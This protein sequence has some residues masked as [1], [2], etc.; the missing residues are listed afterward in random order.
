[1]SSLLRTVRSSTRIA[2]FQKLPFHFSGLQLPAVAETTKR[3]VVVG[4]GGSRVWLRSPEN[5]RASP[6]R[7]RW[8]SCGRRPRPACPSLPRAGPLSAFPLR[9]LGNALGF[10]PVCLSCYVDSHVVVFESSSRRSRDKHLR[11][12]RGGPG[13]SECGR[14]LPGG[15]SAHAAALRAAAGCTVC[16][17][18]PPRPG[19]RQTQAPVRVCRTPRS[20]IQA[21]IRSFWREHGQAA[22][23]WGGKDSDRSQGRWVQAEWREPGQGEVHDAQGQSDPHAPPVPQPPAP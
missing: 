18:P 17:S 7:S 4:G 22:W 2:C 15:R 3:A 6:S 21:E 12:A 14:R 13:P 10:Q 23:G 9:A 8:T 11:R 19:R 1:M 20:R 5:R 16:S